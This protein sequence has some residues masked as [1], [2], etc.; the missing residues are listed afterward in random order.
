MA[1]QW[2]ETYSEYVKRAQELRSELGEHEF[3]RRYEKNPAAL[4]RD[5]G[6]K[7]AF[8]RSQRAEGLR[9]LQAFP[10]FPLQPQAR[11]VYEMI[12]GMHKKKPVMPNRIGYPANQLVHVLKERGVIR[13]AQAR[14]GGVGIPPLVVSE[15]F[16]GG[17]WSKAAMPKKR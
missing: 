8:Q 17:K 4:A 15:V 1:T 2:V 13:L 7:S 11:E 12:V 9:I 3:R 6:A 5:L 10:F 14:T 16:H